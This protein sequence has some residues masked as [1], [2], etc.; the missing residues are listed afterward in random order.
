MKDFSKPIAQN[1]LDIEDKLR[2]SVFAWRGQFSPQ[3]VESI[4]KAY[5][6]DNSVVLDPFAGSGTVLREA[7]DMGLPAC[8]YEI[9]PS[10]WSFSKLHEFA[11][12]PLN[13]REQRICELRHRVE[14]EFPI[15]LFREQDLRPEEIE[16]RIDRI[17]EAIGDETKILFNALVVLLDIFNNKVS[18]E[19]VQGKLQ[20]LAGH[21]RNLAYSNGRIK[22]GLYDARNMP[23][24]NGAAGF[25]LTSPPYINVFN[26]HQ[27]YRRS[28]EALGWDPL[29]VARSE[30][31][32]NRANRGNRFLTVLQYCI[33]IAYTLEEIHRV[34]NSDGRAVLVVGYESNVLGVPFRNADIVQ[35]IAV[36]LGLFKLVLRQKR[37][38]KNRFG[39]SIR[40]D[41]LNFAKRA[42]SNG[43]IL[44]AEVGRT[45]GSAV[46]ESQVDSVS[47]E[48]RALLMDAIARG[49][50][51]C[52]TAYFDGSSCSSYQ[53]RGG[54]MMV[55]EERT[56]Y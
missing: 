7:A 40:E 43:R 5:C 37:V 35:R 9:N 16:V 3:F 41:I 38:F 11:N 21:V 13:E 54:V 39:K 14:E 25:V 56:P 30:I 2:S 46:L 42:R 20:A 32:S 28:V 33:D 47:N 50:M 15:V 53:T 4:L 51:I 36:E 17:G 34:L 55:E 23:L 12:I 22:V 19:L 49:P 18:G 27:N 26:Y 24:E 52:G 29:R 31:G 6:P 10:A 45:V 1:V 48:N 8:G 44:P